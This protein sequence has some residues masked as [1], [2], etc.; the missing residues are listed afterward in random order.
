MHD[1]SFSLASPDLTHMPPH[2][3]V[4]NVLDEEKK[5]S[6]SPHLYCLTHPCILS[7]L[8]GLDTSRTTWPTAYLEC[9]YIAQGQVLCE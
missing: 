1:P 5:I 8:T 4:L 7:A 2:L 6:E 9:G 3:I